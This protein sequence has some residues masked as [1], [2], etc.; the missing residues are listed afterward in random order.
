[1]T[2]VERA[3]ILWRLFTKGGMTK[4][5]KIILVIALLYCLSPVDIVPDVIPVAGFLD[6]LLVVVLALAQVARGKTG[7]PP[8]RQDDGVPGNAKE[9]K[10]KV[11][12]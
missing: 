2:L 8:P 11:V 10:A 4:T 12:P 6:D 9:V 7:N 5:D 3:K 1:M